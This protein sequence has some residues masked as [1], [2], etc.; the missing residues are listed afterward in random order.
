MPRGV[1]T[2]IRAGTAEAI[3][4]GAAAGVIRAATA[5]LMVIKTMDNIDAH[6][7]AIAVIG[8]YAARIGVAEYD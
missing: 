3:M 6:K 1:V 8:W 4:S 7:W 5:G 2:A